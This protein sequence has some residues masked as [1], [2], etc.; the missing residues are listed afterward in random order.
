MVE[1]HP[2]GAARTGRAG[3][4]R[5]L[6][7]DDPARR[8]PRRSER[9]GPAAAPEDPRSPGPRAAVAGGAPALG[10][11]G[12]AEFLEERLLQGT[13]VPP[14]RPPP[15]GPGRARAA[16]SSAPPVT[17]RR[18]R[19]S[20][21]SCA[22][23]GSTRPP[24]EQ[25]HR[26]DALGPGHDA[27]TGTAPPEPAETLRPGRSRG[28]RGSPGSATT[29]PESVLE[30]S[31]DLPSRARSP[32]DSGSRWP[33]GHPGPRG[34]ADGRRR[35]VGRRTRRQS[36]AELAAM[37]SD[38]RRPRRRPG[39]RAT[40]SRPA[41]TSAIAYRE[42]GAPRRG[43]GR[44]PAGGE[45]PR[46][47]LRL[48]RAPRPVLRREGPAAAR[49]ELG[50]AR[51]CEVE[52]RTEEEYQEL[53]YELAPGPRGCRETT[54]RAAGIY[55]EL[56]GEN[57]RLRDVA[58]KVKRLARAGAGE[59]GTSGEVRRAPR[60]RLSVEEGLRMGKRKELS[61]GPLLRKEMR[62]SGGPR[63]ES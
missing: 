27:G 23:R 3:T 36:P 63:R 61:F 32:R 19:S 37:V 38:F 2:R 42:H 41:T 25:Q 15:P 48:R 40:T 8:L 17:W 18:A 51:A 54:E 57:A 20:A 59:H 62:F 29:R 13:A 4:R 55:V 56:Y 52:G 44:V 14:L 50:R 12:E 21:T 26:L 47:A 1:A 58:E 10:S 9:V 6:R 46:A 60:R 35:C 34:T 43:G 30:P 5:C 39:R 16:S 28:A 11:A 22:S 7:S 31:L 33:P 24:A 45:G 49:G 53:R